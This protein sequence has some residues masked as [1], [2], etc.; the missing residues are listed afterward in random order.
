M[1][2][3][4]IPNTET[5]YALIC[6]DENGAE[7]S[8]DRD[9]PGGRFSDKIIDD[10]R[11]HP[12]TDIFLFSHGWKGDVKAAVDQYDRWI[13]AFVN[14]QAD[15][16]RMEARRPGFAPLYMGLHWP[17]LPF[18]DEEIGAGANFA[19]QPGSGAALVE[20]YTKRLGDSPEVRAALAVIFEEARTNAAA[21]MLTDKA[22]NAYIQLDKALAL[23]N[24]ELGGPPDADREPFDPDAAVE[25][26]AE[27]GVDFGGLDL[28]GAI[29]APLRQLSFWTMKKR[30]RTVGEGGMHTFVKNLQ[31]V[32]SKI[33]VH[34]MGHSFGCIVMSSVLGGPGGSTPLVRPIDSCVLVQGAMSLWSFAQ[35]IPLSPGT[36]GYFRRVIDDGKVSGPIV[37]TISRFDTAVG[38]LY[39]VAAGLAQQVAFAGLPKYGAIG[40][41]GIH[42]VEGGAAQKMLPADVNYQFQAR[43]VY[44]LES[45]E[46]IRK[47][48]GLSGA[49]SD[50]DGPEVAH[51]IWQAANPL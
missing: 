44:N 18:G 36:S 13:G 51:V 37:V 28:G 25:T 41:F 45:S 31:S 40:A 16:A 32:S 5:R 35:D 30:A 8:D 26:S 9:A 46:F 6:F 10:V 14:R 49:H 23:G 39:P 29:L 50:I 3:R 2:W 24:S 7:G 4:K 27:L 21:D 17:S 22:R 42:R 34:L 33:R 15:R 38:R 48:N 19:A 20:L 47:G 12:P 11:A 43:K 1:P